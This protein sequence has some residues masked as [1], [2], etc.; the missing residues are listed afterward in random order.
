MGVSDWL[1]NAQVAPPKF[2]VSAMVERTINAPVWM[3]FGAGNIFR[4]YIASLQQKLLNA[5]LCD[6][7]IIAAET[8]DEEI[9]EKIYK[10]YDNKTLNVILCGDGS[11]VMEVVASVAQAVPAS[12]FAR[13]VKIFASPSL[14][15]VSFTITEKGYNRG[16]AMN[17]LAVLM[18]VRYKAGSLPLALVSMDNCSRNG[19]RIENTMRGIAD[20]WVAEGRAEKAFAEYLANPKLVAYPWSMIDKITPRP[21]EQVEKLLEGI[22]ITDVP[23]IVTAKGTYIAPFVNAE[24]AEYLVIEDAFPAGRPP[25]EKAGVYFT[26]RDTVNR[27]ERMKV[28]TCLNPLHTAMSVYGCLLGYT[29]I[30][31]E[32]KDADIVALIRRL[33]YDEGLPVVTD[34][35]IISPK[36]FI[37]EVINERLPNPFMPDDPRRIATDTSQKVGIRFGE[38][39]KSYIE[40]G[41]DTTKLAAIPLAIAGWLRYLLAVND[42]GEPMTLS[43]D[44]LLS[45]LQA[46]LA[47]V[48]WDDASTLGGK[49]KGILSDARVFGLDLTATELG[50]RIEDILRK[51]LRGKWSVRRTLREYLV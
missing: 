32:M 45:E 28:T 16:P 5:G 42:E 10:P 33:G 47:G 43:S 27:V 46:K 8:Y 41:R 21:S 15:M 20:E 49:A 18:H 31:E 30:K 38:T 4:G 37:D 14:Q 48:K 12:D 25:L 24:R 22:G 29:L 19:E 26:D 44:P 51:E 2:D 36:A 13:L 11:T 7:G 40:Q 17:L 9:I 1:N 3:H 35:G 39:I 6:H 50:A 34:P 23:P